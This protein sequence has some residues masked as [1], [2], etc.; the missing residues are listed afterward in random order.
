MKLGGSIRRRRGKGGEGAG[1][2]RPR[3][4]RKRRGRPRG[5]PRFAAILLGIGLVGL[6]AGW[7]FATRVLFPAPPPPGDMREVPSLEGLALPAVRDRLFEAGLELGAVEA[8]RHPELDSGVVVGQGPLPGQ[9]AAPGTAVR[10]TM[11]LGAQ[12]QPMPD[13]ER[14]RGDRALRILEASGFRVAVDS[15]ES[16]LPAGRVMAIQPPAGTL[17]EVPGDV[18]VTVSLGPPRV[19]MPYLL[20]MPGREAVDSLAALGLVVAQIDT[21]FRFGRDQGLVVEQAPPADSLLARGSA[22]R[23]SVG[24]EGGG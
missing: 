5:W 24:R 1:A 4:A 13:V 23:L 7:L 2:A 12:R 8:L 20:G 14:L 15:A 6:G 9:L 3:T 21:V 16:E 11:S 17:L 10:V 19:A 22:V 18:R